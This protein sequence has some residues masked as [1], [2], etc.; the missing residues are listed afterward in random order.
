MSSAA[1]PH[2]GKKKGEEGKEKVIYFRNTM[3]K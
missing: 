2:D 3:S 1:C